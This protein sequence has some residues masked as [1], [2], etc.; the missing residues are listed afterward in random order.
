MHGQLVCYTHGGAAP[1]N[2]AAAEKRIASQK[3]NTEIARIA[4]APPLESIGEVY[5]W[6]LA[7]A[8]TTKAWGEI[9]QNRVAQL[10]R[11]GYETEYTGTQLA[12]DVVLFERAL[13]RS[14]KLG[15]ALVRLDLEGR[16]Q[17]LDERTAGQ[18]VAL[19]KLVLGDLDLTE[20]QRMVAEL[21]V[22]KRMKEIAMVA[23]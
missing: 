8:G 21:V 3:A 1:Q 16:K 4:D 15:E 6:L 12:T 18:L 23:G 2:R 11:L 22:P 5:D 17:A 9:L 19:L 7:I 10:S 14:A 13:D 20:E